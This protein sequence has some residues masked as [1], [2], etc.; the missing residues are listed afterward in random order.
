MYKLLHLTQV[1]YQSKLFL[2]LGTRRSAK[3]M[4]TQCVTSVVRCVDHSTFCDFRCKNLPQNFKEE[5]FQII[6]VFLHSPF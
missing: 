1:R 6:F 3:V 4:C 5:A 2:D